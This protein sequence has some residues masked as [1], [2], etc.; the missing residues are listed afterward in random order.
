[1]PKFDKS[2]NHWQ[3]LRVTDYPLFVHQKN[4][5]INFMK[6]DP[7]ISDVRNA[8]ELISKRFGGDVSQIYAYFKKEEQKYGE[9]VKIVSHNKKK[10]TPS[11]L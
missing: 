11:K 1:M 4:L 8:R 10:P 9:K 6:D 7:I 2:L 5:Y 3:T